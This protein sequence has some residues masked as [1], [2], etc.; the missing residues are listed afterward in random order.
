MVIAVIT[1]V[2]FLWDLWLK[3]SA[4]LLASQKFHLWL[5]S[6]DANWKRGFFSSGQSICPKCHPKE[7]WVPRVSQIGGG[8]DPIFQDRDS[9]RGKRKIFCN[10]LRPPS[11]DKEGLAG[12][13][14][15]A[16][17]FILAKWRKALFHFFPLFPTALKRD[18][19][20]PWVD[21][22]NAATYFWYQA[23]GAFSQKNFFFS[24][25]N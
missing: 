6:W 18:R 5:I 22:M 24:F 8:L 9:M 21:L 7:T 1:V 15:E 20:S 11:Q 25:K 3:N 12:P 13:L 10:F 2:Q 16:W 14:K 23:K 4:F 17:I 19:W